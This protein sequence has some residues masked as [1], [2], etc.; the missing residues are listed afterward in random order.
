MVEGLEL[1]K[2]T[3]FSGLEFYVRMNTYESSG[4]LDIP[5]IP[6]YT[7]DGHLPY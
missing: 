1:L 5:W 7:A 3:D 4:K 2:Y 6:M